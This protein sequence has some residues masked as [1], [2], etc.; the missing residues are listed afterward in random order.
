MS[1]AW[2][3]QCLNLNSFGLRRARN[4]CDGSY[5]S[6]DWQENDAGGPVGIGVY[7]S[8]MGFGLRCRNRPV[9]TRLISDFSGV[10]RP[11]CMFDTSMD[12]SAARAM[13]K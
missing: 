12:I 4:T 10:C 3:L 6:G 13:Q 7:E 5:E 1:C 11:I 8:I 9:G 2:K